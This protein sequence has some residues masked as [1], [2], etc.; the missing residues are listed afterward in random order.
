M[1]VAVVV[2]VVDVVGVVV[3]VDVGVVHVSHIAWHV[4]RT[5]FPTTPPSLHNRGVN[6][7]PAPQSSGSGAPLQIFVPKYVVVG[8]V[9]VVGVV[10]WV[11]V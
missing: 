5:Y 3:G 1:V 6:R 8:V 10:V 2:G 4:S 9:D 11:V 7:A